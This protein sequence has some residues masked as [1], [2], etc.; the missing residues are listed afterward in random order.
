MGTANKQTNKQTKNK[1][2]CNCII[3]TLAGTEFNCTE[4]DTMSFS[5]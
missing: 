1:F 4:R 5:V 3:R 2:L